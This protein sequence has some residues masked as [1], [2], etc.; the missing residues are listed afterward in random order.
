MPSAAQTLVAP[1]FFSLE[2]QEISRIL[3]IDVEPGNKVGAEI[4]PNWSLEFAFTQNTLT[5][6]LDVQ[7]WPMPW[8]IP[9]ASCAHCRTLS[10]YVQMQS[11]IVQLA[12]AVAWN[13]HCD[14]EGENGFSHSAITNGQIQLFQEK[15]KI[16]MCLP[17]K[18]KAGCS[19]CWCMEP[20]AQEYCWHS[21][22][23]GAQPGLP[24]CRQWDNDTEIST[25][26]VWVAPSLYC[27]S[28]STRGRPAL[29]ASCKSDWL[30]KNST[31]C[32]IVAAVEW[33]VPGRS[34]S[35]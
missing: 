27:L 3:H 20:L 17:L 7:A 24:A 35:F 8:S 5:P 30:E 23:H 4:G 12:L 16:K 13:L 10:A 11:D 15:K 34:S 22:T 21:S 19:L 9:L 33:G 31:P 14:R 29:A 25:N 2:D 26:E 28:Q 18:I 1:S 32:L 6:W